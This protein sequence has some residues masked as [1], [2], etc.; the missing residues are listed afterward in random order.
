MSL[1]RIVIVIGTLLMGFASVSADEVADLRKKIPELGDS[2]RMMAYEQ[3]YN[4]AMVDDNIDRQVGILNEWIVEAR[5]QRHNDYLSYVL[6]ARASLFYNNDL[7]DS[8]CFHVP[9]EMKVLKEIGSWDRYFEIWA[10][11]INTYIYG[12]KASIGLHEVKSMFDEAEKLNNK[13]GMGLAYNCMGNGYMVLGALDESVKS[14]RK[15]LDVLLDLEVIHSVVMELYPSYAD[16]LNDQK[17]YDRLESLTVEWDRILTRF[18]SQHKDDFPEG[19]YQLMALWAYNYLAKAQAHIGKGN[20]KKA[21]AD[22]DEVKARLLTDDDYVGQKY[23]FYR[24]QLCILQGNYEEALELNNRR[25]EL[26]EATDDKSVLIMV[27]HQRAQLM[28]QL[29]R[30]AE[31]AHLYRDMYSIND[32][33]NQ[34]DTKNQLNEMNTLFRVNEIQMEKERAQFTFT[35]VVTLV[36]LLA[37][38]VFLVFRIIAAKRLK[39]AHDKLEKTHNDLLVAYDN[40]EETTA[41]KERI[42]SDLRI[43]R[44][45]QMSMVPSMFPNRPDLDIYA[46]MTPAKAVGGD[47]YDFLLLDD[48]LYF[49]LGDVSGKGVPASLFMAQATRLFHTLAKLKMKPAEIA[50]R[51]NDELGADNEQGMFVTMFMGYVDLTNGHLY[52]CNAGHNP[53]VLLADGECKFLEMIPNVPIGLWPGLEY[54]GEEIDCIMDH[55]LFIY[56]DGLN[57]AENREQQQF[58]DERLLELLQTTRFESARQTVEMLREAVEKHRDGAEPNDDLTMLCF[59]VKQNIQDTNDEEGN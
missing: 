17:D 32:S 58:T 38:A 27:R 12:E 8:I 49:C 40:L 39:V 33:I 28:E 16:A 54:E 5:R 6:I 20:V 19:G 43:A 57:E 50:T 59:K 23:L 14:Y 56:T 36:V 21:K 3:M 35:I 52:F 46:S 4:L 24:A 30:Y 48:Y 18:I 51:L 26:M 45:I 55:P 29:G 13:Y 22:L 7:N 41:A 42:E 11:L 47:L 9:K 10:F 37:L 31:A 2:A 15:A 44:D 53:P 34:H 25:M 1:R